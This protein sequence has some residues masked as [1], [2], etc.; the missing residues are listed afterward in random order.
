MYLVCVENIFCFRVN[1]AISSNMLSYI[2][3]LYVPIENTIS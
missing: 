2:D 3:I 1:I